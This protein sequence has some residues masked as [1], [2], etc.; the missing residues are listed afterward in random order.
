MY[1]EAIKLV[2]FFPVWKEYGRGGEQQSSWGGTGGGGH[3][4]E[5]G[6]FCTHPTPGWG[7]LAMAPGL[8]GGIASG[9]MALFQKHEREA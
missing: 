7:D 4:E 6:P 9:L 3:R 5:Q 2:Y 8:S 1:L